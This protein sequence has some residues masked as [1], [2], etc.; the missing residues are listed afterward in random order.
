MIVYYGLSGFIAVFA[1]ILNTLFIL[2]G[3]AFFGATLTLPGLAG[4]ILTI[5]MAVD[6][7]VLIY[8]R[9]R[10]EMRIGKTLRAA[11]ETGYERATITIFD[12]NFTTLITAVIL[13]QFGT[14]P[15]KGFAVTLTIGLIANFITAVYITRVIFDYLVIN[16][17]WKKIS[18]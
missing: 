11:V 16:L 12:S 8:E 2:A 15:V 13:F 1:L 9:I 14:G 17:K 4:M 7:N 3:L 10:E 6:A 18:I 5:G